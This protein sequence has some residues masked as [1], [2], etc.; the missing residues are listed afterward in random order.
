MQLIE[1]FT[2]WQCRLSLPLLKWHVYVALILHL[3]ASLLYPGVLFYVVLNC[4]GTWRWGDVGSACWKQAFVVCDLNEVYH[5]GF[6]SLAV[7]VISSTN[8]CRCSFIKLQTICWHSHSIAEHGLWNDRAFVRLCPLCDRSVQR[9]CCWVLCRWEISIDSGNTGLLPA[10]VPLHGLQHE[11]E[12][13]HVYSCCSKLNT[14]THTRLT[15]L[16]PGLP[17]WAGT[18]KVKPIWILLEQE[19][20]RGSGI[21]WAICKSTHRSRQ[22]TMPAP[23]H[24][25]FYRPDALPATQPTASKHWRRVESWTQE[26]FI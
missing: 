14:H 7:G 8:H 17:R 12:Q 23:H 20:V 22:I 2:P 25:V 16:C 11:C 26:L 4:S 5:F 15:A 1:R 6:M 18:R 9:V 3:N 19:T 21:S 24:S 10:A 13:C